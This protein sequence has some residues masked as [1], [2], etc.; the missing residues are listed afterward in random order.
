[1]SSSRSIAAARNR[2][3]GD[4]SSSQQQQTRPN[5]S[6][7]S[8]TVFS[9]QPSAMKNVRQMPQ[10]PPPLQRSQSM[11]GQRSTQMQ[12][13]QM[14]SAQMQQQQAQP[15]IPMKP[16]ISVSDAIGLTTLRL[17]KVEQFM[18]DFME[19]GGMESI[20]AGIPENTKLVDNSV[21][22]SM[23]NR[24]DAL[25]KKDI[26]MNETICQLE[27]ANSE[28]SFKL[29][30]YI[31]DTNSRLSDID[32]AFTNLEEKVMVEDVV[33]GEGGGVVEDVVEGEEGEEGE[34]N[35]N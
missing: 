13:A 19:A 33:E 24:L 35:E 28:L 27:R 30:S 32:E 8:S 5:T 2:R 22:T 15:L 20:G 29:E 9:Q 11:V 23:I 10:Q 12:S 4:P 3:A 31:V 6:I 18:L 34:E 17:G 7:G 14:Q 26:V 21:L 25:E 1:M 16:K